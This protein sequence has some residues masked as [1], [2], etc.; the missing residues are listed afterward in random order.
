MKSNPGY[1]REAESAQANQCV[2]GLPG[3]FFFLKKA[4]ETLVHVR[5]VP[6]YHALPGR[7]IQLSCPG[8]W[9]LLFSAQ[10]AKAV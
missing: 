3:F 7:V 10:Q 1:Q 4:S 5:S 2:T 8:F 9:F 6:V